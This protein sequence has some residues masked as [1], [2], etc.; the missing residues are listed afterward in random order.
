MKLLLAAAL[1]M[2]AVAEPAPAF[3]RQMSYKCTMRVSP[4]SHDIF[5]G[6]FRLL[7]SHLH[8]LTRGAEWVQQV[9][10]DAGNNFSGTH[11]L[12]ADL[13]VMRTEWLMTCRGGTCGHFG[14]SP[15]SVGIN[16]HGREQAMYQTTVNERLPPG[17]GGAHAVQCRKLSV[18]PCSS[19]SYLRSQRKA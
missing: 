16:A 8:K 12:N 14:P 4:D 3:P 7:T 17:P 10:P 5:A 1:L 15:T 11:Y 2:P 13:E 19:C 9:S 18:Q 6:L